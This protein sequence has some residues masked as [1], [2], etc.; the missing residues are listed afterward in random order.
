MKGQLHVT[1]ARTD[2]WLDRV[3]STTSSPI[4]VAMSVPNFL[5]GALLSGEVARLRVALHGAALPPLPPLKGPRGDA[6]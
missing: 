3:M 1:A 6:R 4:E 5:P 2:G